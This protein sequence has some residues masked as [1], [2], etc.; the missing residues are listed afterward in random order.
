MILLP[1]L[2]IPGIAGAEWFTDLYAGIA[3][4]PG[5]DVTIESFP[6]FNATRGV[7]FGNSLA[8][9]ARGG[10]WFLWE[11]LGA[12]L[13]LAADVSHFRADGDNVKTSL[14][15]LSFLGM[16]RIPVLKNKEFPQGRIQPYAALGWTF[17]FY[18]ITVD[19]RPEANKEDRGL[20]FGWDGRLGLAWQFHKHVGL[21]GEYRYTNFE[22]N[23]AFDLDR[24]KTTLETQHWLFGISYRY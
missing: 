9:G 20:T 10:H 1:L 3:S 18:D 14:I 17:V 15:P 13:G 16:L 22:I 8:V 19:F 12:N 23:P 21:F 5:A 7:S 6:S 11:G 24:I 2:A 4:T